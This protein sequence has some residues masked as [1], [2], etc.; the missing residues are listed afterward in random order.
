VSE[1]YPLPLDLGKS[2]AV[3]SD[4]RLYAWGAVD[5]RLFSP[6]TFRTVIFKHLLERHTPGPMLIPGRVRI[7]SVSSGLADTLALGSDGRIY[8]W[9]NNYYGSIGD[10]TTTDRPTPTAVALPVGVRA[11]A[12]AVGDTHSLALGSDGRVYA[13][14]DNTHGQLGDGT[15]TERHVPTVVA[16]PKGVHVVSISAGSYDSMA[17]GSDGRLY[18]W[19][20]DR[21]GQLGDGSTTQ[22]DT[23]EALSLP[24]GARISSV[25]AGYYH[26]L[27]LT[28]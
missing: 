3:G 10:G 16:L 21:Y 12:V 17:V 14:G 8:G 7:R 1:R 13:W 15:R 18:A 28:S 22:R 20:D 5:G 24:T 27:A 19:G 25:S 26:C 9:G 2:L 23:P 4:G 11:V 6:M